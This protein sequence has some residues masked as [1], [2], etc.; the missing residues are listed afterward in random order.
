MLVTFLRTARLNDLTLNT[1]LPW[2]LHQV[3]NL[4][5]QQFPK[6]PKDRQTELCTATLLETSRSAVYKCRDRIYVDMTDRPRSTKCFLQ[7]ISSS[8]RQNPD[9]ILNFFMS[10]AKHPP[11]VKCT[12]SSHLLRK[13]KSR[14]TYGHGLCPLELHTIHRGKRILQAWR[15]RPQSLKIESIQS[16]VAVS[17]W[18]IR[19]LLYFMPPTL[20]TAQQDLYLISTNNGAQCTLTWMLTKRKEMVKGRE[21]DIKTREGEEKKTGRGHRIPLSFTCKLIILIN[22]NF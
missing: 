20:Q 12:G 11:S 15:Y 6:R 18:H 5:A 7:S 3:W 17:P 2:V 4:I 1:A 8:K 21:R 16:Q 14:E 10:P 19:L 9:C 22:I 13:A